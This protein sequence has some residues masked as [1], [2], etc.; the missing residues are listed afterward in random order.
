MRNTTRLLAVSALLTISLPSCDKDKKMQGLTT[1]AVDTP[2]LASVF[3]AFEDAWNAHDALA[4]AATF[5][6]D[7]DFT[8]AFGTRVQGA[9][10]IGA[11]YRSLFKTAFV[12]DSHLKYGPLRARA[13]GGTDFAAVDA[14]WTITG[15]VD[16]HGNPLSPR[17]GLTNAVFVR[18]GGGW[19]IIVF[20]N[21]DFPARPDGAS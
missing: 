13:L 8:N 10:A 4:L 11:F 17:V 15:A 21:Q 6:T 1:Q 2:A 9:D 20:H 19:R 7:A 14:E 12:A 16:P 5:A 18:D 3:R